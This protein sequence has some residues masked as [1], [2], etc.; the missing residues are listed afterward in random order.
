MIWL[1]DVTWLPANELLLVDDC[2]E[3][4]AC[5]VDIT[6]DVKVDEKVD[7]EMT[8]AVDVDDALDSELEDLE[9]PTWVLVVT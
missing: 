7:G 3:V 6:S 5:E 9:L 8:A 4:L 2:T 1:L